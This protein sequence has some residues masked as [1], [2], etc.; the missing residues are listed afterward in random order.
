MQRTGISG[1]ATVKNYDGDVRS[2][3]T[4]QSPKEMLIVE[5]S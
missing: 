5:Q 1:M 2:N 3:R 4:A